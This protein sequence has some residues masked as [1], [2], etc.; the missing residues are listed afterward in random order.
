MMLTWL[1]DELR[2]WGLTV[3][4]TVGWRT[5]H[6]PGAY[7]P[8]GVLVH[9]T[10]TARSGQSVPTLRTVTRGRSDLPGPLYAA[11]I[12]WD[13]EIRIVAAG[14]CNH[15]GR[16]GPLGGITSGN[17][18]LV[19]VAL[20]GPGGFTAEMVHTAH[21]A[22]AAILARLGQEPA[23]CWGH[24]EWDPGRKPDPGGVDMDDFRWAVQ[25]ETNNHQE[26]GMPY[27]LHDLGV[28]MTTVD[29]LY[30]AHRGAWPSDRERRD[31]AKDLAVKLAAGQDPNATYQWLTDA[32]QQEAGPRA[33][34]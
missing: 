30:L 15:A 23:R 11:L 4:E 18:G 31:W 17:Q 34:Q 33:G 3:H 12:G 8:V 19:G 14:R 28:A 26:T 7:E 29:N 25:T 13:A 24:K 5:R 22:T 2:A 27:T 21:I 10:G 20:E 9:H 6:Y 32:L 1:A 16:G